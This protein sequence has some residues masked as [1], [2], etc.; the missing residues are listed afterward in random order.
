[1]NGAGTLHDTDS[2]TS[3]SLFSRVQQATSL[4][5]HFGTTDINSTGPVHSWSNATG[6]VALMYS[7]LIC[8]DTSD[9]FNFGLSG[10]APFCAPKRHD[11][12]FSRN[13]SPFVP[14]LTHC[15]MYRE[16]Y[17]Y[18]LKEV[19]LMK[20]QGIYDWPVCRFVFMPWTI[21]ATLNRKCC[22]LEGFRRKQRYYKTLRCNLSNNVEVAQGLRRRGGIVSSL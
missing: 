19:T 22:N 14:H 20:W 6:P 18:W 11:T 15:W 13:W 16:T 5:G 12:S 1:M 7:Q 9:L 21:T 17:S 2:N 8:P 4:A 10:H 3:N